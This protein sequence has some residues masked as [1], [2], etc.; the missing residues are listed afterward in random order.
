MSPL[1]GLGRFLVRTRPLWAA[2]PFLQRPVPLEHL[3]PEVA[4]WAL[5]LEELE[6]W[7]HAP[8]LHPR[9][10]EPLRQWQAEAQR[11]SALEPLPAQE[12][13]LPRPP[14]VPGRKWRQVLAFAGVALPR[15][16][17]AVGLIEWCS[18]KAHLGR[19]LSR[20]TGLP[21]RAVER[22]PDL[23]ARGAE[24]ARREGVQAR[25]WCEDARTG[26]LSG[27]V[28][29]GWILL[30]LHA[31]GDL[32]DRALEAGAQQVL[33]APCCYHRLHQDPWRPRSTQGR[34]ADPIIDRG[35]L[36]L[37][38]AEEV[39]AN[40]TARARRRREMAWR[41]GLD[42]LLREATGEDRHHRVGSARRSWLEG[43][44]QH[45]CERVCARDGLSLPPHPRWE[46]VEAEGEELA[47]QARALGMVRATWRW[48]LEVWLALDRSEG[49]RERGYEVEVGTFCEAE[50]TP[51]RILIAA[52]SR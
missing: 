10:P 23:C 40:P 31:C 1:Q 16:P 7:E 38:T 33:A 9:A 19:G 34:A 5:A 52:Q 39:V 15:L 35:A 21:L 47:R 12:V 43:D 36:R 46:A 3:H 17:G 22:E 4:A 48:P 13:H 42:L 29:P 26:E 6:T 49:L 2:R 18:G 50:V 41:Q 37:P 27:L 44:F 24:L 30:S 51:R 32:T 28:E 25:W 45:F 8:W 11:L 20:L 14:G